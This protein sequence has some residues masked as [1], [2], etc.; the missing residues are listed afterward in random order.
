MTSYTDEQWE[1]IAS[2]W[3]KAAGQDD[4]IRFNAPAFVRW[5]KRQGYIRDYICLPDRDLPG[6]KGKF[7]PDTNSVFY[8]RSIWDAAERGDPHSIWT[9]VHEPCHAIFKHRE[10]RYRANTANINSHNSR[11]GRDEFESHRLT[12][13]ILAPFDKADFTLGMTVDDV[14]SRFG[15]SQDAAVRRL[16]EFERLYRRRRG[17]RRPLPPGIIDFLATQQRKGYRVTSLTDEHRHLLPARRAMYEGDPCPHC[18]ALALVRSGL[19]H[20]C[21]QCSAPARR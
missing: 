20:T 12:A 1:E 5:L 17:I 14:M 7:D 18:G 13:C 11:A 10:V 9:L 16:N 2:A 4:L 8:R 15:L 6:A 21:D 19:G 3:R